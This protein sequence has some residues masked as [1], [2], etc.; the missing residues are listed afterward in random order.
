MDVRRRDRIARTS[1]SAASVPVPAVPCAA[2]SNAGV[3]PAA[4]FT[5]AP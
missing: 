3:A 4:L 2:A 1:F 5:L